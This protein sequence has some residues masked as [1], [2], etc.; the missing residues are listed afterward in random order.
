MKIKNIIAVVIASVVGYFLLK[1]LW[2]FLGMAFSL[3]IILLQVV[4]VL[5][6]AATIY[7]IIRQK[8]LW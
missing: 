1:L 6:I 8:L 2:W 4:I 3:A 5:A 7:F